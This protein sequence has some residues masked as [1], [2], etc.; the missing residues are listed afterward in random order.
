MS[1]VEGRAWKFG[2]SVDTDVIVPGKYL[3][4]ELPEI[5]AHVMEG[6]RPGFAETIEHGDI[7]VAGQNFGTGSAREVAPRAL[8]AAGIAA[9]VAESF[10]RI[11]FRNCINVGLPPVECP[12]AGL[13]EEGQIVHIDI[14]SGELMVVDTGATYRAVALPDEIGRILRAGGLEPFLKSRIKTGQP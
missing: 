12:Q 4:R 1:S 9:V 11:F 5:A 7:L 8:Q 13:I 2:D 6:I 14:A 3:I 10:A